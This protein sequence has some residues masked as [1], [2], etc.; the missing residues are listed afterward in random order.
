MTATIFGSFEDPAHAERAAGALLD[1]GLHDYDISLLVH[2]DGEYAVAKDDQRQQNEIDTH[3]VGGPT[4]SGY[5]Y[6]DTPGRFNVGP[7][8]GLLVP[9]TTE[10]HEDLIAG[11]LQPDAVS[12]YTE[13]PPGYET[14]IRSSE[15]PL[16]RTEVTAKTGISTTTSADAGIGAAKGA[17][18]GLGVGVLAAFAAVFVPGVG[19]VFGAGALAAAIAG[20]V[21]AT[22]AGVIAGGVIG[23]M[24]DQG[25]PEDALTVYRD[26]YDKGGAIL[27]VNL[28]MDMDRADIEAILAKYGAQNVDLYGVEQY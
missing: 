10:A 17:A 18:V 2:K 27:A 25:V 13:P 3:Q 11:A 12:C 16:E 26:A 9:G 14:K 23:Y 22:G 5:A 7:A 15:G 28:P 8:D 19:L 21:G 4:T 1:N 20:T 24:K 6:A